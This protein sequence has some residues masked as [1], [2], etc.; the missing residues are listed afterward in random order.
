MFWT[1]TAKPSSGFY[2]TP[3]A[4]NS[5][6]NDPSPAHGSIKEIKNGET[7]M[8]TPSSPK[9][10]SQKKSTR[11]R[12]PPK[13]STAEAIM[14]MA[15]MALGFSAALGQQRISF[16]QSGSN[17]FQLANPDPSQLFGLQNQTDGLLPFQCPVN[18]PPHG[19]IDLEKIKNHAVSPD[20]HASPE[21][22]ASSDSSLSSISATQASTHPYP[23]GLEEAFA[24]LCLQDSSAYAYATELLRKMD[25][26]A[27]KLQGF[28]QERPDQLTAG[29]SK[30]LL[31]LKK[32]GNKEDIRNIRN[33]L[34]AI[35][36]QLDN[37]YSIIYG[38]ETSE[39]GTSGKNS[40]RMHE[41][42]AA[43][44]PSQGVELRE[45]MSLI[46]SIIWWL[47]LE[48]QKQAGVEVFPGND[49]FIRKEA[50]MT[51]EERITR[52]NKIKSFIDSLELDF[53]IDIEMVSS[54]ARCISPAVRAFHLGENAEEG[55]LT[56]TIYF[57]PRPTLLDSPWVLREEHKV[58]REAE[59]AAWDQKLDELNDQCVAN[60]YEPKY[61]KTQTDK[62]TGS[63]YYVVRDH[64]AWYK[65]NHASDNL[66]TIT[67]PS[68]TSEMH[69]RLEN[70]FMFT[71]DQKIA[72]MKA[73]IAHMHLD[74]H[75]SLHEI[76]LASDGDPELSA[77][78]RYDS[79][80]KALERLDPDLYRQA[81]AIQPQ[82]MTREIELRNRLENE[83]QLALEEAQ[84]DSCEWIKTEIETRLSEADQQKLQQIVEKS[85]IVHKDSAS[86]IRNLLDQ[87][88]AFN[89]TT[90]PKD[91]FEGV[92]ASV[93]PPAPFVSTFNWQDKLFY[94]MLLNRNAVK[95]VLAGPRDLGSDCIYDAKRWDDTASSRQRGQARWNS[96]PVS[97]AA[98]K[99][100]LCHDMDVT[101]QNLAD[102]I[103]HHRGGHKHLLQG[104][105]VSHN[106]VIVGRAHN[107]SEPLCEG[108]FVDLASN[109]F[110]LSLARKKY[111]PLTMASEM[112][113]LKHWFR[114]L[115]AMNIDALQGR[116]H[117]FNQFKQLCV[118]KKLPFFVRAMNTEGEVEFH[119]VDL[120]KSDSILDA[121]N[122]AGKVEYD[123]NSPLIPVLR[124]VAK[125][126]QS[127]F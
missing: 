3:D 105:V 126:F 81:A 38:N 115:Q 87:F 1:T 110:M 80:L 123:A 25:V 23:P 77:Y 15:T 42:I 50:V 91:R 54:Y 35:K 114:A 93:L 49:A 120:N 53:P 95:P 89:S 125:N 28:D 20:L 116:P 69:I 61:E 66:I 107:T 78:L 31:Q 99:Q 113:A 85:K 117:E 127:A 22:S 39:I 60:T 46:H 40:F 103:A 8:A 119:Q 48:I 108:I 24:Y 41:V 68:G 98:A 84:F 86:G 88:P 74:R 12:C 32:A 59:L 2:E 65:A 55:R 64:L 16:N 29:Y 104:K 111:R 56:N 18:E 44:S 122:Q 63:H 76:L 79:T 34:S 90:P 109:D 47:P 101:M 4:T 57:E 11:K 75:H 5:K 19:D 118:E 13:K 121:I 71:C 21:M 10:L 97:N 62:L 73:R 7:S 67:G 112:V 70:M 6:N 102:D 45:K 37:R 106:E 92:C 100:E 58:P 124:V 30:K 83:R 72:G 96:K 36:D 17:R 43:Q 26:I 9:N 52:L 14:R 94:G 27:G 82:F 51:E 33:E